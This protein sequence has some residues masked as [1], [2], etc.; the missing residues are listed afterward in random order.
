MLVMNETFFPT[1]ESIELLIQDMEKN[2]YKEEYV[3]ATQIHHEFLL[4]CFDADEKLQKMVVDNFGDNY[5]SFVILPIQPGEKLDAFSFKLIREDEKK[6]KKRDELI[7]RELCDICFG[8]IKPFF[9]RLVDYYEQ[10]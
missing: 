5:I 3:A 1:K 4:E 2:A 6:I 8:D 10:P 9:N 7:Y